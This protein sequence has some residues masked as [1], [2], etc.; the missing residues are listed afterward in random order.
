MKLC[1]DKLPQQNLPIKVTSTA[2]IEANNKIFKLN[3]SWCLDE[4][5]R[6][7]ILLDGFLIFQRLIH[8]DRLMK[9]SDGRTYDLC[10]NDDIK[11]FMSKLT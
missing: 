11:D 2:Y 4:L 9:S 7:V 10:C 1:R 6:T 8:G 5:G 3:N